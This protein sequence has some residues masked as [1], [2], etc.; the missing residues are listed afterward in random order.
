M[1]NLLREKI[2]KGEKTVGTFFDLDKEIAAK[3]DI[4]ITSEEKL[5][6]VLESGQYSTLVGDPLF[7]ELLEDVGGMQFVGIPH[8]AV[9][10]KLH[11]KEMPRLLSSDVKELID[12]IGSTID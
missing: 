12:R 11:W 1:K 5:I 8:V 4:N 7:E 2:M 9:S 10:S 6:K 3:G